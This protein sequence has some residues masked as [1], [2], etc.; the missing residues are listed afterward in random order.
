MF[1]IIWKNM[2]S[3]IISTTDKTAP[4]TAKNVRKYNRFRTKTV[5]S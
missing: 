4:I 3:I 2:R 1:Q 5:K